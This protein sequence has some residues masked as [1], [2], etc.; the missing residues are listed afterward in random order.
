MDSI[1]LRYSEGAVL[2]CSKYL[3]PTLSFFVNLVLQIVLSTF[4]SWMSIRLFKKT[5][6]MTHTREH[7]LRGCH[8]TRK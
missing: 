7:S 6:A 8:C 1:S 3:S 2:I 5:I 4:F